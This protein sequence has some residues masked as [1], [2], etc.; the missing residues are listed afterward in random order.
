MA[1][2]YIYSAYFMSYLNPIVRHLGNS[3]LFTINHTPIDTQKGLLFD[4]LSF[5]LSLS[6]FQDKD[7]L[8]GKEDP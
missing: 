5:F 4:Y 6:F 3:Q 8:D 2:Q 7:V 1:V